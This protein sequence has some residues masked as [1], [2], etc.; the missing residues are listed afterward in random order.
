MRTPQSHAKVLRT[1][2]NVI[3]MAAFSKA[4]ALAAN[5]KDIHITSITK[6]S[7]CQVLRTLHAVPIVP[8]ASTTAAISKA[9]TIAATSRT[10]T[11]AVYTEDSPKGALLL[12][13]VFFSG[14]PPLI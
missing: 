7:P 4:S 11:L 2:N 5:S 12:Q 13:D 3:T 14:P 8:K 9:P 1:P 6:D 10:P